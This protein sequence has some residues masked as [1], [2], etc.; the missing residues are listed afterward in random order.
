M[1]ESRVM[2][3][4]VVP[5]D[6]L[7]WESPRRRITELGGRVCCV[8]G[9]KVHD[10]VIEP[11]T[12]SK[13][14]LQILLGEIEILWVHSVVQGGHGLMVDEGFLLVMLATR[15]LFCTADQD[16]CW[17]E[18]MRRCVTTSIASVGHTKSLS[19]PCGSIHVHQHD[20]RRHHNKRITRQ[21]SVCRGLLSPD[22]KPYRQLGQSMRVFHFNVFFQ[23]ADSVS[24]KPYSCKA[25]FLCFSHGRPIQLR[26][27]NA[28]L[29][30][31][32]ITRDTAVDQFG[33]ARRDKTARVQDSDSNLVRFGRSGYDSSVTSRLRGNTMG[34]ANVSAK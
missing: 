18:Y 1:L 28:I 11:V 26:H 6:M 32:I 27:G 34:Q 22:A 31:R 29:T 24:N 2:P 4:A 30:E 5:L 16:L 19:G 8:T 14:S 12:W 10:G 15:R 23:S 3:L 20:M 17:C 13:S 7:A 33:Y 21:W 25:S 9:D